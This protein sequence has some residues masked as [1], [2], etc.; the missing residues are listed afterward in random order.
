MNFNE[1]AHHLDLDSIDIYRRN[2]QVSTG[3]D[4]G[5]KLLIES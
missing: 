5:V 1:I 4:T 3:T 2:S